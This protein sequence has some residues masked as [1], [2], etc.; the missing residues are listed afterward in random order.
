[1][2]GDLNSGSQS[3]PRSDDPFGSTRWS[4]VLAAGEEGTAAR[5][6]LETLCQS[7]WLPVYA[8]VRR[9]ASNADDAQDLT[10]A[11]FAMLLERG[12]F[13]A[14]DPTRGRFRAFLLT[15][16]RNFLAN[17]HERAIALKRGGGRTVISLDAGMA[18][19][20]LLRDAQRTS[21]PE[22]EFERRWALAMLD[23]VI[24]RLSDE[25]AAAGRQAEFEALRLFL[26]G[27]APDTKQTDVARQLGITQEAVRAAIYRLRKRYRALLRD[28][29]AQMVSSAKEVDDELHR[30]FEALGS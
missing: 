29:I 6:A 27:Q 9:R 20:S 16:L 4:V 24:E 2:N 19:R 30:L 11:F 13:G 26:T 22:Q 12:T 17:E 18:E 1:M 15:A 8:Y 14:A 28:E 7:Y 3:R 21:T 5:E 10:Q 23:R 25:Q